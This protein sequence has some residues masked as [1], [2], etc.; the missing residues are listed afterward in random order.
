MKIA[1]WNINGLR[2][3]NKKGMLQFFLDNEKP[4]ILCLQEVKIKPDQV[5]FDFP[6]Y[7]LLLNSARRPGYSGTGMLV[8]DDLLTRLN[9]GDD[10]VLRDIPSGISDKYHLADDKF[11]DTNTEGRVM[12]LELPEFYLAT[13]YTPN[14][15]AD[16]SRLGLRHDKWDPA[17]LDYM[18]ELRSLKP[19]VFCGDLNVAAE[20]I[21]LANPRQNIGK[22]GFTDEERQGFHNYINDGFVDSFRLIH[23]NVPDQYTWWSHWAHARERNVGWRIDY[24]LVDDRL[25]SRI[26]DASIYQAQTGSDHCPIS[27]TIE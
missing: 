3:V 10:S 17:F 6:G 2:A 4:D 20:E 1:S 22:H 9:L 16:L 25:R 23:G 14:A 18:N 19:V 11:G 13:V 7:H 21:D 8:V 26:K 15:K 24:F 27:I 12:V 5:D